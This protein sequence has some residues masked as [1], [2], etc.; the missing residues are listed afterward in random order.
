[1]K[2]RSLNDTQKRIARMVK[3]IAIIMRL[4]GRLGKND[5]D[6]NYEKAKV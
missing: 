4:R 6:C 5:L 3:R 1:M 2:G